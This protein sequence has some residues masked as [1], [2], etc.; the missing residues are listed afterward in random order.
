MPFSDEQGERQEAQ[1]GFS[2]MDATTHPNLL[3]NE[4]AATATNIDFT[5]EP[6]AAAVRRGS[7]KYGS[8]IGGGGVFLFGAPKVVIRKVFTGNNDNGPLYYDN[9]GRLERIIAGAVT[10]SLNGSST[11]SSWNT[12]WF[13]T[14]YR[15]YGYFASPNGG[16]TFAS[17]I[18]MV[19]DDGTTFTQWITQPPP[20]APTISVTTCPRED[21]GTTN[22]VIE[23]SSSPFGCDGTTFRFQLNIS[24]IT[25]LGTNSH[26]AVVGDQGIVQ[27]GIGASNPTNVTRVSMDYSIGTGFSNYYHAEIDP[28]NIK[29][30]R[31]TAAKLINSL[32]VTPTII[33]G[34]ATFSNPID[35]KLR[36]TMLGGANP[37]PR[38]P[39]A[40][41]TAAA[42]TAYTWSVPLPE[43]DTIF[44]D[45]NPGSWSNVTDGRII[46]E[47]T[48]T[49]T[50]NLP[51]LYL[52]GNNNF[53][54]TDLNVGYTYW[55]TWAEIDPTSGNILGESAPSP[56]TAATKMQA[57]N[58]TLV[59][60]N[61]PTSVAGVASGVTHRIFY[62][63]GG[64]IAT[65]YAVG[66][67]PIATHTFTDTLDDISVLSLNN[68]LNQ[69][70]SSTNDLILP[71]S[72][73]SEPFYDRIFMMASNTLLWSLPG[74]PA[75][76]PRDSNAVVGS[77][78]EV[79]K[80]LIAW[81]PQLV[82]VCD[83]SVFEVFGNNFEGAAADYTINRSG[84]KHGSKASL[85][86]IR[87]P[88]G[89]PLMD[90]DGLHMYL[91]GQAID[92]PLTWVMQQ[93]GDIWK[94]TAANDPAG[95]K[96]NRVPPM[97][98]F[99]I[100]FCCAAFANSR[101]YIG[102]PSVNAAYGFC[103]TLLV[104]D[105][106]YQKT[107]IF[108]YP[109][110]FN[111]LYWDELFNRLF[112]FAGGYGG[113]QITQLETGLSDSIVFGGT[114]PIIY[115]LKSKE[116]VSPSDAQVQN[117][118]I[119]YAGG[120]HTA[121]AIYDSTNTTAIA[122]FS[123]ANESWT[124]PKL[125]GTLS[126]HV[127]FS[128]KGTQGN[129]QN[130]LYQIQWDAWMQP[131]RVSFHQTDPVTTGEAWQK[132]VHTDLDALGTGT[133]T[134]TVFLD[135]VAISTFTLS[136]AA[137]VNSV[138][139]AVYNNALPTET[140]GRVIYVQ[141]TGGPFKHYKTWFTQEVQP[142]KLLFAEAS[143]ETLPAVGVIK[144]WLPE[145][146]V[147]TGTCTGSLYVD[148][149]LVSTAS[150]VDST[151]GFGRRNIFEVGLPNITT[152]K[153]IR[154]QYNST[155][156]FKYW[157]TRYEIEEKPFL[158]TTW[159][160]IYKKIGGA[161]QL[162]MARFMEIDA[163]APVTSTLTSVWQVDGIAVAT[164]FFPVTGRTYFD[165]VPFPP[166]VMGYQYQQLISANKPFHLWATRLELEQIGVKGFTP[167]SI[168]GLPQED[169]KI[170]EARGQIVQKPFWSNYQ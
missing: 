59:D 31:P 99:E 114:T 92:T 33:R 58:V 170:D 105:F 169:A 40:S 54:L 10:G 157:S 163:E 161:S 22:T 127:Q 110:E 11:S 153:T 126:N 57:C 131:K 24:G 48:G 73:I 168:P 27:L 5:I 14:I 133:V 76:F 17:A 104:I 37:A 103:D 111:A 159:N 139:R 43:F 150:F 152:G 96:G 25:N 18:E 68:P 85:T 118:A 151:L 32:Q 100:G 134:A 35:Q 64:Y 55:E 49:Y 12:F 61:S 50:L 86:I 41:P 60:N 143:Y 7:I 81:I 120:T 75:S 2:G 51:F 87:T 108:T 6:G 155:T 67:V 30:A 154:A 63:Q 44:Q 3:S 93:V 21:I 130:V 91:P 101:L 135:N 122:S 78:D 132:E 144:T 156:P 121:S 70:L 149:I 4:T 89:I 66:T 164:N 13:G 123:S 141:Y 23:G 147:G 98:L 125:G 26:S 107:A 95:Y 36:G 65:P 112:A 140:Y 83:H 90:Y 124:I 102:Y 106:R 116:W 97:N 9:G 19:K 148:S 74:Q 119:R 94:G 109:F 20:A 77:Q 34:T 29:T 8:F 145:L 142:D 136:S 80:G 160:M 113:I 71:V 117:I 45:S 128:F 69:N 79:G 88:Y 146:A 39:A 38:L 162:D 165:R 1:L 167:R 15:N 62:R 16:G 52:R 46:V 82:V 166:G 53:P 42:N 56:A 47:G 137:I 28:T 84:S 129:Q 72:A 158:K 138:S 115:S